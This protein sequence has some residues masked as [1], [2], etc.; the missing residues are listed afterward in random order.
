MKRFLTPLLI[1]LP[2]LIF[3]QN[4][5]TDDIIIDQI[6]RMIDD[7]DKDLDYTELIENYWTICENKINVNNPEELNQLIE[8]HLVS[9]F[10]VDNINSYRKDFGDIVNFDELRFVEGI[11]EMTLNILKPLICF[12]K[13]KEKEKLRLKDMWKYGKHQAQF[14]TERCFNKKAGY[15]DISDSI[16]YQN[17]NK[18]Y[19]GSPQKLYLR[20]NFSYRE[21][22]EA[23][24]A[25]E[26]DPGEYLFTPKINDSI[27]R[28]IGSKAYK[29][30]DYAS[31]H[32][33]MRDLRFVKTIALGDYQLAFGQGLTL[34]S[35]MAFAASGG[36]LLRKSKKIRASKSANET[37]YL[38][39]AA[40]TLGYM[41]LELTMFYSNKKVDAN[42]SADDNTDDEQHV[43]ALQQTGLHRT[44]G[45]LIDRHVITQQLYGGNISF[46]GS[47]Y[48]I[49][50]TIHKT[51]L[52]GA[53]IPEPRLYNTFY[54]KGKTLVNQGVDFYY[55]LKKWAFYGEAAMSDNKAPAVLFGTSVQPAGYIEFDVFYR[56]YDKK[57]QNLYSNA[58]ASGSNTRNEKGLYLSTSIT[59]APKWK[60]I[61]TVDFPQSV[62]IKTSAYAPSRGQEYNLQISHDINSNSLFFIEL[63]YRDKEK[64][65]PNENTYMRYLIH[66]R[67]TS[68]RFHI[69]YPVGYNFILKNRVE[70]NV[71]DVQNSGTTK[72]YLIYQDILYNPVNQPFSFAF[73][74]ALFNSPSGAVYAYENDVLN[75]FSIGSFYH[76]GMRIYLL[77]KVKLRCRLAINAKIGCTIYSDVNEIGSGL[78]KIEGNVKTDGKL[79][80][81]WKL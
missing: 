27:K 64:N 17:P 46:R 33:L 12:E 5:I 50:Y 35:G 77:G 37:G 60:L 66:E 81:V 73:R 23:G 75:S 39:G 28:M 51:I 32:F 11:D 69:T 67:K 43:T 62:W 38:R 78:E 30:I 65:G 1:M 61:A 45:E 57:Y 29:T 10:I 80:L 58:F 79:Q 47:N 18:K 3:A 54:F 6:E 74:Y 34:G 25:L 31:F 14:L 48:Q 19:L 7:S 21:K 41:N 9:I 71:S 36:S 68:L 13:P 55:V 15:Q 56:Y 42:L 22:I 52:S 49:G 20:Y 53:L 26:K 40:T 8:L 76:K 59:F 63:K 4:T 44:Y 72:S 2:C 70:Y 16:L 24:F